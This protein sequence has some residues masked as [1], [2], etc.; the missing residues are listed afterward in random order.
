MCKVFWTSVQE[1]D[2]RDTSQVQI[3]PFTNHLNFFYAQNK[4]L[5]PSIKPTTPTRHATL[6]QKANCWPTIFYGKVRAVSKTKVTGRQSMKDPKSSKD[7]G[8]QGISPI[9][10]GFRCYGWQRRGMKCQAAGTLKFMTEAIVY[11][12]CMPISSPTNTAPYD[13]FT[14]A[15][16]SGVH[17]ARPAVRPQVNDPIRTP[18]HFHIVLN[19]QQAPAIRNQPSGLCMVRYQD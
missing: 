5:P 6:M 3:L 4:Q 7:W 12:F 17:S 16:S 14:A 11:L 9:K 13:S 2:C 15:I 10:L 1:N 19:H 18:D 8:I